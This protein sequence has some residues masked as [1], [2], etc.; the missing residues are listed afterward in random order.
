MFFYT[1]MNI[2]IILLENVNKSRTSAGSL[3]LIDKIGVVDMQSRHGGLVYVMNHTACI[4]L[5]YHHC[6][7]HYHQPFKKNTPKKK[8]KTNL[9]L[10]LYLHNKCTALIFIQT[11]ITH[12]WKKSITL[13]LV[14]IV[15]LSCKRRATAVFAHAE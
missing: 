14:L 13:Y 4:F 9:P 3:S 5:N 7:L 11:V 1:I 2:L 6:S 10:L 8:K 12:E 15:V